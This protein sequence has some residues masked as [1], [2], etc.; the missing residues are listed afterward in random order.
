MFEILSIG[1][2]ICFVVI[3]WP[4]KKKRKDNYGVV[5]FTGIGQK[6]KEVDPRVRNINKTNLYTIKGTTSFFSKGLYDIR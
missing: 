2:G 4:G 1:I 3:F 5:D 6:L